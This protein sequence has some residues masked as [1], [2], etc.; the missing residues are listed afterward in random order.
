MSEGLVDPSLIGAVSL[1]VQIPCRSPVVLIC[2]SLCLTWD[3]LCIFPSYC[4]S[5]PEFDFDC[6]FVSR[7]A[8]RSDAAR[9]WPV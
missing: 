1:E 2:W 4:A 3:H 7:S 5:R 9:I 8:S 6:K